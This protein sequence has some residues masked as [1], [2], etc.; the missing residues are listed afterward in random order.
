MDGN[1]YNNPNHHRKGSRRA[2]ATVMHGARCMINQD[3]HE[4][5]G[6]AAR[7]CGDHP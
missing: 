7:P 1:D 4:H 2:D 6:L 5:M 3:I